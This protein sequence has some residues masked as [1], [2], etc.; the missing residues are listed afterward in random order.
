MSHLNL[1]PKF[2]KLHCENLNV[3]NWDIFE[4]D[5]Q[6][7]LSTSV[8]G[9]ENKIVCCSRND[10]AILP[11]TSIFT[12]IFNICFS[13]STSSLW[14]CCLHLCNLTS[15]KSSDDGVSLHVSGS[16]TWDTWNDN[17]CYQVLI[18]A[19]RPISLKAKH[20]G[21]WREEAQFSSCLEFLCSSPRLIKG[22]WCF[23]PTSQLR[24]NYVF[25]IICNVIYKLYEIL[26]NVGKCA[27]GDL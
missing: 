15:L 21:F 22:Q 19:Y 27:L 1:A 11:S 13:N 20:F 23:C 18:Q 5:F 26:K 17:W 12:L 9:N 14:N 2:F 25:T 4:S 10:Q 8:G 7:A 16:F 6:P 3:V 24:G